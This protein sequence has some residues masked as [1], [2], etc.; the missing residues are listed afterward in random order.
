MESSDVIY[1]IKKVDNSNVV[2]GA[3]GNTAYNPAT[4]DIDINYGAEGDFSTEQGLAHELKHGSQFE[5]G[6]LAFTR[7]GA[8]FKP[9]Y[10]YQ[11]ED[12]GFRR[13]S[14]FSEPGG[15]GALS[16]EQ[17]SNIMKVSYSKL[18]YTSVNKTINNTTDV[19]FVENGTSM[20]TEVKV[21]LGMKYKKI[22]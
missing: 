7:T 6:Q 10:D 17:I 14:L 8:P 16:E 1:R 21:K 11:D 2:K 19:N 3:S 20:P 22:N 9:T 13:Q 4:K 5:R 12:E 18:P 15:L